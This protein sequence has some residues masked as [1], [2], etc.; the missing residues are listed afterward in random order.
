MNIVNFTQ[1]NNYLKMEVIL[2]RLSLSHSLSFYLNLNRMLILNVVEFF[3]MNFFRFIMKDNNDQNFVLISIKIKLL[4]LFK[5]SGWNYHKF[6]DVLH[7]NFHRKKVRNSA[8]NVLK[9]VDFW[10]PIFRPQHRASILF[11]LRLAQLMN[12]TYV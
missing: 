7:H 12:N 3:L 4:H 8:S 10:G 11:G 1:W 9:L 2:S 6:L 5:N